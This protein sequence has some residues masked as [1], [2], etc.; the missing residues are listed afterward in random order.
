MIVE[1]KAAQCGGVNRHPA[2]ATRATAVVIIAAVGMDRATA[3]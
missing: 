3:G 2:A 1:I